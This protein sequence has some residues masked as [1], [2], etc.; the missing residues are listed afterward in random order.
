[1][2]EGHNSEYM[3]VWHCWRGIFQSPLWC[4]STSHGQSLTPPS[5][6]ALLI[7]SSSW[8]GCWV[9]WNWKQ[10]SHKLQSHCFLRQKVLLLSLVWQF[11]I[12]QCTLCRCLSF[13]SIQ[14]NPYP[15]PA[16]H[17]LQKRSVWKTIN[18]K[19]NKWLNSEKHKHFV[20]HDILVDLE[21]EW[22]R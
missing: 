8:R 1:M 5:P 13:I 17:E 20:M 4:V 12:P 3:A 19:C 11:M 22:I 9:R 18:N 16:N 6:T 14:S 10:E 2:L 21:I 7:S 15:Q